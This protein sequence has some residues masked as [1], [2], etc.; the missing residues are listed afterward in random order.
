MDV[1]RLA[2]PLVELAV[3]SLILRYPECTGL[4]KWMSDAHTLVNYVASLPDVDAHNIA[5]VHIPE[6]QMPLFLHNALV[7]SEKAKSLNCSE[8]AGQRN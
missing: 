2:N 3:A 5:L 7:L 4:G 1:R 8:A 6:I